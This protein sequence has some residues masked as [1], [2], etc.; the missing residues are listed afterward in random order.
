[1]HEYIEGKKQELRYGG[2]TE[3]I[4]YAPVF[5]GR[6]RKYT[7]TGDSVKIAIYD[8]DGSEKLASTAMSQAAVGNIGYL[9]FDT[10]T[11]E[12][13]VGAK[14]T[15][16]GGAKGIIKAI[17]STG[18]SGT[19]QLTMIDGVFV[20]NEAITDDGPATGTAKADGVLYSAVYY[21]DWNSGTNDLGE[22]YCGKITIAVNSIEYKIDYMYFDLV[23]HPYDPLVSSGDID[24]RHPEWLAAR[25]E[26]WPDWWPAIAA[27]HAEV[28]RR[29]RA[30]GGRSHL[31]VD[32]T[33]LYPIEMAFIEQEISVRSSRFNESERKFWIQRAEES[34]AQRPAFDYREGDADDTEIDDEPQVF[35]GRFH[36]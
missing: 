13:T 7:G 10:Q 23:F 30:L 9:D 14:L 17:Y 11:A 34:W 4:Y 15:G 24:D 3:R 1:M 26:T 21:Y 20:D 25:S 2:A 33:Q 5:E 35:S 22:N 8:P 12:F 16:A 18:T 29:V 27:G 28:A 19:M 31:I 6:Q 36:R 32:R